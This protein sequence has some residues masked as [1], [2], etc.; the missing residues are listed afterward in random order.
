MNP[1][2]YKTT[3][4]KY[5]PGVD[6]EPD[7]LEPFGGKWRLV[8]TELQQ[9]S[10]AVDPSKPENLLIWTWEKIGPDDYLTQG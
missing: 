2:R 3:S 10:N 5:V 9:N 7:P 1:K 4:A 6:Q 8:S